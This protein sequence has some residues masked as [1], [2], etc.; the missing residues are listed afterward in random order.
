MNQSTLEIAQALP[1]WFDLRVASVFEALHEATTVG[2]SVEFGVD[3][4]KSLLCL[5]SLGRVLAIDC[6]ANQ[7]PNRSYSGKGRLELA[8]EALELAGLSHMVTWLLEDS[9]RLTADWMRA[10]IATTPS[11]PDDEPQVVGLAHI[12]GGHDAPTVSVD[13]RNTLEL[14]APDGVVVMDD[15]W[16]ASF[17]GVS[18]ALWPVLAARLLSPI[19]I[20]YGRGVFCRAGRERAYQQALQAKLGLESRQ[21]LWLGRWV[22]V[23]R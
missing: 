11:F 8:R 1:G 5:A 3:A 15:L 23:W 20:T 17:P 21:T 6:G 19:A 16:N 9:E 10:A 2:L 12:D 13:L 14:L 7:E 22:P 18:E 4:G